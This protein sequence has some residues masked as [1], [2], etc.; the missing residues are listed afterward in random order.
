MRNLLGGRSLN[1]VGQSIP[2]VSGRQGGRRP[3]QTPGGPTPRKMLLRPGHTAPRGP[4]FP[5]RLDAAR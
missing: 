4:K 1:R 2:G 3:V 5:Q